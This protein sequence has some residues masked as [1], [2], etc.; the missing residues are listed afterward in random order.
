MKNKLIKEDIRYFSYY[1]GDSEEIMNY[2]A[3]KGYIPTERDL[4]GNENILY[5]DNLVENLVKKDIS[6]IKYYKGFNKKIYNYAL[7]DE[8]IEELLLY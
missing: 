2:V 3:N 4:L 7:S 6:N 5:H 1:R 8:Q